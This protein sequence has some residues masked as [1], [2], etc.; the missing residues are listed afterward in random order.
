MYI[1]HT[2]A[3][4]LSIP[5]IIMFISS[6]QCGAI[7]VEMWVMNEMFSP[8]TNSTA[9]TI[10]CNYCCYYDHSMERKKE[11]RTNKLF[12]EDDCSNLVSFAI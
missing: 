9:S 3:P 7:A 1:I 10:C 6:Y 4:K 5:E 2:N 12:Q 11:G 8:N